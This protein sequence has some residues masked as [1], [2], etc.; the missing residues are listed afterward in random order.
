MAEETTDTVPPRKPSMWKVS[1]ALV[2]LKSKLASRRRQS[3]ELISNMVHGF[4]NVI[5]GDDNILG[6]TL[7][8]F[9]KATHINHRYLFLGSVLF[10]ASYLS[11][12]RGASTLCNILGMIYPAYASMK[13]LENQGNYTKEHW[14][15][16]WTVFSTINLLEIFLEVFL[17]WLPMYSLIKFLFLTW[18]MVPISANGSF[19]TYGSIIQPLFHQHSE[20]VDSALSAVTQHLTAE[21]EAIMGQN[22]D[23]QEICHRHQETDEQEKS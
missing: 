4:E 7:S 17:V 8:W 19:V 22:Q 11:M 5:D 10:A 15:K 18:C 9:E 3:T 23:D 12:G 14:L 6:S 21:T 1:N 16:Y 20:A 13:A 2:E